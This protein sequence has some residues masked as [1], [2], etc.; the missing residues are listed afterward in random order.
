MNMD[1]ILVKIL[2]KWYLNTELTTNYFVM[3]F[4]P[5]M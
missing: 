2:S 5:K 4:V 1:M 3:Q